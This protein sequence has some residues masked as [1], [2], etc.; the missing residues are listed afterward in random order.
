MLLFWMALVGFLSIFILL[1]LYT[2]TLV[3]FFHIFKNP[4]KELWRT[5]AAESSR[6]HIIKF[7]FVCFFLHLFRRLLTILHDTTE[8]WKWSPWCFKSKWHRNGDKYH[9]RKVSHQRDQVG[10]KQKLQQQ[11]KLRN[12]GKE[13]W[14]CPVSS[15]WD[16]KPDQIFM[17]AAKRSHC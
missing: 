6:W 9:E 4:M 10:R 13:M 3:S 14:S 17:V 15:I 12:G 11:A 2:N 5:L 16:P 1:L 7:N 8:S